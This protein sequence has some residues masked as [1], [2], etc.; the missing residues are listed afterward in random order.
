MDEPTSRSLVVTGAA[1]GL[2]REIAAAAA[3]A[4]YRVGLIDVDPAVEN[5]ARDIDGASGHV[6][7]VTDPV[8]IG[9]ALEQTGVSY[10]GE[11]WTRARAQL[12]EYANEWIAMRG[13]ACETHNSGAES[14]ELYDRR[15]LCLDERRA[16]LD[17]MLTILDEADAARREAVAVD[18]FSRRVY[19]EMSA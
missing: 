11:T 9:A 18:S 12:D 16:G 14:D 5:V 10:A 19:A 1:Q 3:Q 15:M 7:S 17:G 6:A 2:G 4:G 13:E 8:A